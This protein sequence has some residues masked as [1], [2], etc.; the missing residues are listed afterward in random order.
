MFLTNIQ[1]NPS[2]ASKSRNFDITVPVLS[3][4]NHFTVEVHQAADFDEKQ[5]QSPS[6]SITRKYIYK[7]NSVALVR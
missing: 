2:T 4:V 5:R 7:Q 3:S 6:L 1:N